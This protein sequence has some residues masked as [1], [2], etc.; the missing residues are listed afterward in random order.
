MRPSDRLFDAVSSARSADA[1]ADGIRRMLLLTPLIASLPLVLR[2][3][4]ARASQIDP[5]ET[6]VTLPDAIRLI[7]WDAGLDEEVVRHTLR[8]T[9]ATWSMQAGTDIWQAAGWLGITV[10]Q[11]QEN[12]GHHHPDFQSEAAEAFGD[13]GRSKAHGGFCRNTCR[14]DEL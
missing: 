12:Y 8:H 7:P 6:A 9:A 10:E 2:T 14:S 1:G 3:S 11:L 13:G 4:A 5:S